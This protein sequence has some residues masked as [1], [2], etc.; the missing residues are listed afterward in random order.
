MIFIFRFS[1]DL[2]NF[3]K[4]NIICCMHS[5][6][7]K[8]NHFLTVCVLITK[9]ILIAVTSVFSSRF[10]VDYALDS[11]SLR[12]SCCWFAGAAASWILVPEWRSSNLQCCPF[13][14]AVLC[15]M[16][17]FLQMYKEVVGERDTLTGLPFGSHFYIVD[18][19]SCSSSHV[20]FLFLR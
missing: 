2:L 14:D 18:G 15:W 13:L 12:L 7:I 17:Q 16:S 19:D 10:W 6:S 9:Y 4:V 8:R 5:S 1:W 3:L 20:F 11:A